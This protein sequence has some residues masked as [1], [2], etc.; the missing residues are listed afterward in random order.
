MFEN[1][2]PLTDAAKAYD[3]FNQM[4]VQKGTRKRKPTF[5]NC[6]E[7]ASSS[8]V[9]FYTPFTMQSKDATFE[10]GR[11]EQHEVEINMAA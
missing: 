7:S 8:T 11:M 6:S 3:L 9:I 1:V 2:M 5:P 10:T 4:K